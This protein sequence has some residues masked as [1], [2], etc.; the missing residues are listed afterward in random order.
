[1]EF[2]GIAQCCELC[3]QLRG[4]ADKRQVENVK[5]ALQHNLGLGGAVVVS[6]YKMPQFDGESSDNEDFKAVEEVFEANGIFKFVVTK[7]SGGEETWIV[8]VK[9]GSGSVTRGGSGTS[10]VTITMADSDLLKLL[11][12]KLNAQKAFFMGLLKIKGNM[13][14][15]MKLPDFLKDAQSIKAKL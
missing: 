6:L 4:E 14:L 8:D 12:G 3:W 9:N 15:A 2:K 10:D 11:H 7:P 1:M 13:G 5:V